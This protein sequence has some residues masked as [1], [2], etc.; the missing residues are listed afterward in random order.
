[1]KIRY[2]ICSKQLQ[3]TATTTT[4]RSEKRAISTVGELKIQKQKIEMQLQF[5]KGINTI[6]KRKERKSKGINAILKNEKKKK[7]KR[8]HS[9]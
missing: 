6:L 4:K 5:S 3:N 7:N 2:N 8:Q 1:M 9:K